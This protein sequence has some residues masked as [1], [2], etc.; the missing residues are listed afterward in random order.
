[1]K[2]KRAMFKVAFSIVLFLTI[3]TS[4]KKDNQTSGYTYFVSKKL[5]VSYQKN[6]IINLIDLASIGLPEVSVIKPLIA[7][8]INVYKVVYKTTIDGSVINASAL[9]CVPSAPGDY[10]VLSFQNGTNTVNSDAPSSNP[11]NSN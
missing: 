11:G 10:P 3:I 9:I 5:V 1:M 2:I 8:D 4:C 6:N 7:S